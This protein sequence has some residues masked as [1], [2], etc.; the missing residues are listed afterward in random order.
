VFPH[1]DVVERAEELLTL[2]P[3]AVRGEIRPIMSL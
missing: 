1:T 3:R 2:V